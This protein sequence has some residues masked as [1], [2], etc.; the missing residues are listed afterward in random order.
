M[1][2]QE[3]IARPPTPLAH[4]NLSNPAQFSTL[5]LIVAMGQCRTFTPQPMRN[6]KGRTV[7]TFHDVFNPRHTVQ[8]T[9]WNPNDA[10]KLSNYLPGDFLTIIKFSLK[11]GYGNVLEFDNWSKTAYKKYQPN[12]PWTPR[13]ETAAYF[14]KF[15]ALETIQQRLEKFPD[16][17]VTDYEALVSAY[18]FSDEEPEKKQP[19]FEVVAGILVGYSEKRTEQGAKGPYT[20]CDIELCDMNG[21]SLKH[22]MFGDISVD[23]LLTPIQSEPDVYGVGSIVA[24][25]NVQIAYFRQRP[26]LDVGSFVTLDFVSP[27]TISKNQKL[28]ILE[29]YAHETIRPVFQQSGV[30]IPPKR[31]SQAESAPVAPSLKNIMTIEEMK[32]KIE[33]DPYD[34][35]GAV[36]CSVVGY[37]SSWN[38][39]SASGSD[40]SILSASN[41]CFY[42]GCPSKKH[43][44]VPVEKS[45]DSLFHCPVPCTSNGGEW[46]E[47]ELVNVCSL[48]LTISDWTGSLRIS[49]F[50]NAAE[51]LLAT[52][53]DELSTALDSPNLSLYEKRLQERWMKPY[54]FQLAVRSKHAEKDKGS[55]IFRNYTLQRAIPLEQYTENEM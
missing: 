7:F 49:A 27:I 35:N 45:S 11:R 5:R 31:L 44:V 43:K 39:V 29:N 32:E 20:C 51:Q 3:Y 25:H 38:Q 54:C 17:L 33:P 47:S 40:Q 46:K 4:V 12:G 55:N 13:C 6:V 50:A 24:L 15:G 37:I 10:K 26:K 1:T 18:P 16:L 21:C 41:K 48:Q 2:D 28:Q 23:R 53:A 42:K 34:K 19:I 8:L 9:V 36:Y 22:R 14:A 52:T 30:F